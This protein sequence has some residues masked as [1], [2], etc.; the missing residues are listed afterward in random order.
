M[1]RGER[2]RE[3]EGSE[4]TSALKECLESAFLGNKKIIKKLIRG[5]HSMI[6]K[7]L[8]NSDDVVNDGG[9]FIS[10]WPSGQ[11]V[12]TVLAIHISRRT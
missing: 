10:K 8:R 4:I 7:Y 2:E 3:R 5:I 12:P 11:V 1:D 9:G 6:T